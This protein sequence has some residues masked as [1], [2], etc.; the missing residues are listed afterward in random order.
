MHILNSWARNDICFAPE[1]KCFEPYL[2]QKALASQVLS[3]FSDAEA[4]DGFCSDVSGSSHSWTSCGSL[5]IQTCRCPEGAMIPLTLD[6]KSKHNK[7]ICRK[8]PCD[9]A[10]GV[11]DVIS[12]RRWFRRKSS[13]KPFFH[14]G[15]GGLLMCKKFYEQWLI[16]WYVWSI[17]SSQRKPCIVR[18][19][20]FP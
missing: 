4:R 1:R 16:Y 3:S 10:R 12:S 11:L 15:P 17:L 6:T 9:V 7:R 20:L 2:Q 8:K 14:V 5:R 18:C 13:G 19:F